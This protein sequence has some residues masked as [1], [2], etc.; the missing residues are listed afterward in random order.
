MQA[1]CLKPLCPDCVE[2]HTKSHQRQEIESWKHC[3]NRSAMQTKATLDELRAIYE[4]QRQGKSFKSVEV[5][6]SESKPERM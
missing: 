4:A 5:I 3:V 6:E 2:T 1:D